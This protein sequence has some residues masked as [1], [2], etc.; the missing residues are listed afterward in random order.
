M[1]HRNTFRL[2]AVTAVLAVSCMCVSSVLAQNVGN[3]SGFTNPLGDNV[4]LTA[5]IFKVIKFLLSLSAVLALA[6]VVVGG[7]YYVASFGNESRTETG[8]KA[9]T[10]AIIGLLL[11]GASFL[12]VATVESIIGRGAG[13]F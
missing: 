4:D 12:I 2:L 6:A 3:N 10:Y 1:K 5:I 7:M 8:K 11:I 9:I 13:F